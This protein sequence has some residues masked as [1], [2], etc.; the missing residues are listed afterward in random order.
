[1]QEA[2][3]EKE[4]FNHCK[5]DLTRHVSREGPRGGAE[6]GSGFRVYGARLG[7]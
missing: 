1:M 4:F 3:A 6:G 5:Q 7:V 2:A